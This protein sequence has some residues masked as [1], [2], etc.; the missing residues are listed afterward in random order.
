K[1][2][3]VQ[4][5]PENEYYSKQA[6]TSKQFMG[7]T[8]FVAVIMAIG[9]IFGV[10]NTMFAAIS[11][12]TRDIGV[13]RIMGF[14]PSQVL[15]PFFVESLGIALLGGAVGCALGFLLNG[16]TATSIIGSGQGGGKS[17]VFELVIDLNVLAAG[18]LFT[19]FMGGI[20]GLLPALSAMRLKPLDAI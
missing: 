7:A 18:M 12:R 20:G 13:L 16:Y 8:V 19:L 4:A 2:A 11:Q 6:E 5:Q 9:G 17:V 3:T 10:M 1:K 14:W 15:G